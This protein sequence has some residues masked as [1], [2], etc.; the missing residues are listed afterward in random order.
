LLGGICPLLSPLACF[1]VVVTLHAASDI[2][3]AQ[4]AAASTAVR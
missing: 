1:V 3:A 4:A 2:A